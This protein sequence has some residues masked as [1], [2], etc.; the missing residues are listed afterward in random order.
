MQRSIGGEGG[1]TARARVRRMIERGTI[2]H[3]WRPG[4]AESM[5]A[6]LVRRSEVEQV[7]HHQDED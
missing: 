1:H 7:Q 6:V 4:R 5:Y 2:R 3:Y